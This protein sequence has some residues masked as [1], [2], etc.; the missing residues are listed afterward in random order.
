MTKI[1]LEHISNAIIN[2]IVEVPDDLA[3]GILPRGLTVMP[4]SR[5]IF[6]K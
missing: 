6:W 3:P 1:E 4:N 2:R 5:M